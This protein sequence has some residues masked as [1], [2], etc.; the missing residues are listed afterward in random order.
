[1]YKITTIDDVKG[2]VYNW[3]LRYPIDRW[4]R[5]K[6]NIPFNSQDHRVS[7]F[8]DQL[9]EREEDLLFQTII[10]EEIQKTKEDYVEEEKYKPGTGNFLSKREVSEV[11]AN[12]QFNELDL[13][14]FKFD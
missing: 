10:E 4:W 7:N 1:M 5:E 2:F 11:E 9:I 12:S 14:N 3:N 8:I 6:H 13:D